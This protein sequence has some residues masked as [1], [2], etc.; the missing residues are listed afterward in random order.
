MLEGDTLSVLYS[1]YFTS[2]P[3]TAMIHINNIYIFAF[4]KKKKIG[5]EFQV[6][7]VQTLQIF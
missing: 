2:T 5:L 6:K 4:Q 7:V 3:G 1:V